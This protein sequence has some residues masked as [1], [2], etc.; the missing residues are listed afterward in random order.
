MAATAPSSARN[1]ET[2]NSQA[3]P[4]T[5]AATSATF[6]PETA[7]SVDEKGRTR[8]AAS[9]FAGAEVAPGP[10]GRYVCDLELSGWARSSATIRAASRGESVSRC[11]LIG[12]HA[13]TRPATSLGPAR[14]GNRQ[15]RRLS[16]RAVAS[17]GLQARRVWLR[18]VRRSARPSLRCRGRGRAEFPGSVWVVRLNT[19]REL[20]VCAGSRDIEKDSVVTVM[21][22]EPSD[23]G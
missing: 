2:P 6:W 16:R 14:H 12:R 19:A 5:P 13:V 1:R 18:G 10:D 22:S 9:G 15:G 7:S 3:A 23:F 8:E 21:A 11:A 20:E 4:S 17:R